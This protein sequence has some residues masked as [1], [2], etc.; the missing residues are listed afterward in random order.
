MLTDAI[1]E[2]DVDQFE[3]AFLVTGANVNDWWFNMY[4]PTLMPNIPKAPA[5]KRCVNFNPNIFVNASDCRPSC[6]GHIDIMNYIPV[7]RFHNTSFWY[8]SDK[9]G[10]VGSGQKFIVCIMGK[11][12]RDVFLTD[13]Y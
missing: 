12:P 1:K 13:H 10:N 2:Y 3:Y 7:R 5:K 6:N 11:N 8:C 4:I 9:Y